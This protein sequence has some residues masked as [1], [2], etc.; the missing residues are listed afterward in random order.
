L[1]AVIHFL[2]GSV[3]DG[4]E[5]AATIALVSASGRGSRVVVALG[6]YPQSVP[7]IGACRHA[8]THK[9]FLSISI[10]LA[11]DQKFE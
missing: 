6:R 11:G 7:I 3:D 9:K 10:S 8:S 4:I 5:V 1:G 2:H